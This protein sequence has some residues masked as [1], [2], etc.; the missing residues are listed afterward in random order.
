MTH[1]RIPRRRFLQTLGAG[2]AAI[3]QASWLFAD[4]RLTEDAS[5]QSTGTSAIGAGWPV[6]REYDREHQQRVAMPLGG[7]GTGTVS[8]GGR[9][10]LRDWEI[11]NRPAKGYVP[12]TNASLAGSTCPPFVALHVQAGS[13]R[14]VRALEGP[15]DPLVDFEGSHGSET[16]NHGLP[17]F[18]DAVFAAAYPLAQV[19][20]RDADCPIDARLE[21]FNPLIPADP[22]ASGLPVAVLRYALHNRSGAPVTASV[23]ASIPNFI[24][25]DGSQTRQDWRGERYPI[26]ESKNRN[27]RRAGTHVEGIV[28]SSEGVA[29]RAEAW[30]TMALATPAGGRVSYRTNWVPRS[31]GGSLLDFW[32]DFRADGRLDG[33]PSAAAD[34]SMASLAVEVEIPPQTTR[35]ITFLLTWHFPNRRTWTPGKDDPDED[36]VGNYYTTRFADA[37]AAAEAIAPRLDEYERRT[38]DFVRRFCASDLPAEVREA[39][40][41]NVSTLRTQ[42]SF[43][44]PDGRLFGFEGC[45]NSRGCCQ[46]SCTHVWNYDQATAFL[47]GS[48]ARTMREVE[49][50]HATNAEGLMSMRV[51]LPLKYAQRS[52]K[53]AADGQMGCIMKVHREWQL[54]GDGALLRSLWPHVRRAL[55][56]CW[57][58]GGWDADRDGVMEGCQHNT[59]DVEYFGPNPQM[60]FWY[61]GALRAAEMMARE[62][63][64][65]SFAEDCRRLF[66]Q[67]RAWTEAN[68]FNGDYFEHKIQLPKDP[69]AIHPGLVVGMG[70]RDFAKPDYQL[71]PGCLV[72]QL[73]GQVTAHVCGLGYLADPAKV[74]RTLDSI[75]SH[76]RRAGLQDHFNNM[77]S[78]ALGDERALLMASFP[79]DRPQFPFPYFPEVMT[80]FEY[81]AAVGM[82][83]EGDRERGL[84]CIRDIRARYDG[85]RR[86][87]FDEAECGHHYAR[88]MASWG[89]VLALTGFHYSA[90]DG[91]LTLAA[92]PA[93]SF[94]A[95]GYAWGSFSVEQSAA[96]Y[97]VRLDIAE[98]A[99]GLAHLRL[100]GHGEFSW[101]SRRQLQAGERI[102]VDVRRG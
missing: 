78:F 72:D 27:T 41:F 74:R 66:D 85:R 6:L 20:L 60:E 64:D 31:W 92:R 49:F 39:A 94:W 36:I 46:G 10:D 32:D 48:L 47:F 9:G 11:M 24:G 21:A 90:V 33:R 88:A 68:L 43:R 8:L 96:G 3:S 97:R 40:L 79:K 58:P 95:S 42:T 101:D 37:W 61:L 91:R 80:G 29:A 67:G 99:L 45:S 28:M 51:D 38:V 73:V 2:G 15:L 56:F 25:N 83:Y 17:R 98:G 77:R 26:G 1:A 59:M 57:V 84:E 70:A 5:L 82:I 52:G 50:A 86:N 35:K 34:A 76:N 44:T 4:E 53:A 22:D 89:A 75:W 16:P 100:E 55:E 14:F 30:G 81:V 23:C 71:G 18:Q 13:R 102:D 87:P 69:S 19:L 12:G 93:R 63:G 62:A 7:I 65:A 54:S